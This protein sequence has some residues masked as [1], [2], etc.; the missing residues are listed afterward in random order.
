MR[1]IFITGISGSGKTTAL[2]TLED[3][4]YY[5]VDNIPVELINEVLSLTKRAGIELITFGVSPRTKDTVKKFL[6]ILGSLREDLREKKEDSV[7]LL[8]LDA[9]DE[10][11]IRRYKE[12][13]RKHP[14]EEGN[15][16]EKAIYIE[17][18]L[19]SPILEQSDLRIDTT[20]INIHQLRHRIKE[21]A[22]SSKDYIVFQ[23]ISFGFKYGIP[24]EADLV[25]DVRFVK[26]PNFVPELK[27]L[28]G[29]HPDVQKYIF[30]DEDAIKYL[31]MIKDMIRFLKER[32]TKE[33]RYTATVAIGCTG[34]RHRSIAFA[35]KI[36]DFLENELN[37]RCTINHRDR[38]KDLSI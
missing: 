10:V 15:T 36:K 19:L 12:T 11:I 3:L 6:D 32:L 1:I 37:T 18:V 38:N 35:E 9:K 2:K 28:D 25:F 17:R 5:T 22:G 20:D 16:I 13:R 30:S 31:D 4:G 27:D 29:T 34:G 14:F 24:P 7:M 23:V 33:G 8:F 21:I 26:N